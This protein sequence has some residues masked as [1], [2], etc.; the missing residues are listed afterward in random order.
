MGEPGDQAHPG[1]GDVVG[2][3]PQ[4]LKLGQPPEVGQAS[5]GD[6]AFGPEVV[7]DPEVD[8]SSEVGETGVG[9]CLGPKAQLAELGEL[10]QRGEP[11]V[12]DRRQPEVEACGGPGTSPAGA[13][14]CR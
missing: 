9:A 11:E 8:E 14:S 10:R 7:Q 13:S 4:F 5:V 12:G 6:P 2:G 3:E 1:V